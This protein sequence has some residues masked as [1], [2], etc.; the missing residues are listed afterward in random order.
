MLRKTIY[1]IV[2]KYNT[3]KEHPISIATTDKGKLEQ[4]VNLNKALFSTKDVFVSGFKVAD[5][6]LTMGLSE[7]DYE[8]ELAY[9]EV[10]DETADDVISQLALEQNTL[11]P[12][13]D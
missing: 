1:K 2:L 10:I 9:C 12:K 4:L 8:T 11:P 3:G 13:I 5:T 7:R 6:L